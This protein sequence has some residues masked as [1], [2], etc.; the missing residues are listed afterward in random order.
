M[1]IITLLYND[2]YT[3]YYDGHQL[4]MYLCRVQFS[5]Y[6]VAR[7]ARTQLG[8]LEIYICIAIDQHPQCITSSV[9]HLFNPSFL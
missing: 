8:I 7:S 2:N 6:F 5:I 4:D 9:L 1:H 3:I